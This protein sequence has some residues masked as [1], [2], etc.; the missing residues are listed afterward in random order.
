[1]RWLKA[2]IHQLEHKPCGSATDG[3]NDIHSC[4]GCRRLFQQLEQK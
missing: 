1:M 2:F 3:Q 4:V